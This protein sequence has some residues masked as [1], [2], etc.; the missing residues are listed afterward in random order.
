[1]ERAAA[2][3]DP[4]LV[5]VDSQGG[6]VMKSCDEDA[7]LGVEF[8]EESGALHPEFADVVRAQIGALEQDPQTNTRSAFLTAE[9][10]M[11]VR[12]LTAQAHT[13]YAVIVEAFR[14]RDS[15]SAAARRYGLTNR[16]LEILT[17][18]MEGA[19]ATEIARALRIAETTVQGC[20]KRLLRKT[21]S[22]NRAA[23]VANVLEWDVAP[24]GREENSVS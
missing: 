2:R 14:Q 18:V 1:M 22:R 9:L 13:L 6:I 12:R 21:Q 5:I 15:L 19:H 23:M 3:R 11:R 24:P 7:E 17:L 4:L 16:E 10:I 20:F 8:F